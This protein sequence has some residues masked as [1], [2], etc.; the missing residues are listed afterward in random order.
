MTDAELWGLIVEYNNTV[1][2]TFALFL[3][4]VSGFLIVAYLVGN[5]L[6]E[7]QAAIV[8]SGFV[9]TTSLFTMSTYGYGSRAIYLIGETSEQYRSSVM[10]T[11]PALWTFIFLFILGIL[12]CLKFMWDVRHPK[13]E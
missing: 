6:T 5:K 2:S 13:A 12:A 9:L 11:W 1:L 3:T 4:L 7:W 10:F 8:T